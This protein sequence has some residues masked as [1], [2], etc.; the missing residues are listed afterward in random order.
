[1]SLTNVALPFAADELPSDVRDFISEA[2][3]RVTKFMD[4]RPKPLVGFY[5]SCFETVYRAYFDM[6][7]KRMNQ[8]HG[9]PELAAQAAMRRNWLED[10]LFADP[11]SSRLVPYAAWSLANAPPSSC[12]SPHPLPVR[13]A[14]GRGGESPARLTCQG[15]TVSPPLPASAGRG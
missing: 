15:C 11:F 4:A 8:P 9:A 2:N 10:Q 3:A 12:P 13:F 6:I 5:P 14:T 7:E 1:M